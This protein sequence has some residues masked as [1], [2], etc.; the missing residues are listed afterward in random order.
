[1]TFY[2]TANEGDSRDY[3]FYSEEER[4]K[5]LTLD[6]VAFNDADTLQSDENLGRLKTTTQLG[7]IDDDGEFEKIFAYGARSFS[8][9]DEF[10]NLV[11]DSSDDF[12]KIT[13]RRI[14]V[15]FNSTNDENGS[16]DDR[17]DD[18]G[19]EPEGIEIGKVG[20]K[21][22][23]FIGLERVGGIMVYNI[24]NPNKVKFLAY[25]NN[26]DFTVPVEISGETNPL[27]GDLAPEGLQF[28]SAADSPNGKPL[29]V[30][31]NEVSGTTTIFGLDY[32]DDDDDDDEEDEEDDDD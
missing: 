31:G 22:L 27:V 3:D 15:D 23:A 29:L 30:V 32:D 16:F 2:A 24:T 19:T 28:I 25:V 18:K 20:S 21:T 6:E 4:V 1:M 8:I 13:A 12:A 26:R 14:P 17:S 11:Y 7:D 10:G 9:W 5:D